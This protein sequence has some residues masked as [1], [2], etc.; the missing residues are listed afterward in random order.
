MEVATGHEQI[1]GL[2]KVLSA[3]EMARIE[4]EAYTEGASGQVF[5]SAA[6][7]GIAR[8]AHGFVKEHNLQWA[9]TLLCGK[10]NNGG[11]AYVAGRHLL[12]MGYQVRALHLA[13]IE[14]SSGLCQEMRRAFEQVGGVVV[15]C[16]H[17][18]D[19]PFLDQ[20]IILDGILG[21]GFRGEMRGL[22]ATAAERANQSRLPTIAIDIPSGINGNTGEKGGLAI[23]AAVTVTLGQAKRGCFVGQ[24]W[25]H[26]GE[27]HLVDF[28]LDAA[29]VDEAMADFWMVTRK[30]ASELLPRI[31]RSRHK[32]Q[33][34]YVV[35]VAGSEGMPGAALLA[36]ESA[37]RGGA[38]MM[39]LFHSFSE[40]PH[41]L[42]AVHELMHEPL[43]DAQAIV[44]RLY[45]ASALF[46]GPGMGTGGRIV[47]ILQEL[48]PQ[49]EIPCVIDADGL[50]ILA[51]HEMVLPKET[52]LTPHRGEMARLLGKSPADL[53]GELEWL[54]ACGRYAKEKGV[55]LV[56]KGGPTFVFSPQG[57]AP[58]LIPF[59]DPGMATAG[60]GDVL[61]GI[62][63]SLLSQGLRPLK[64]ALLGCALHGMAGERS[65][66]RLTSY[67][68]IAS[69]ITR[70]LPHI[71]R[72]LIGI[73][74]S[75]G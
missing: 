19:L 50:A 38:G 62:L 8:A 61:T 49:V 67:T 1:S 33:A 45:K 68:M 60:S 24:G 48:L 13:P 44:K 17:E 36:S 51:D 56:L 30:A 7:E 25:N 64:A 22:F 5:M 43:V 34:G 47:G 27:L 69:D 14:S 18:E 71:F 73:R 11:D 72:D 20:G 9:A 74:R 65:A 46:V 12:E 75:S 37:L 16:H 15:D 32:Y 58:Y 28:G 3:S 54:E 63:A 10:G 2:M 6:G 35:G 41:E 59:G 57:E 39:R 42:G 40:S 31:E 66:K 53:G 21:T 26:L 29:L 4:R 70:E 55:V 52:I 23:E